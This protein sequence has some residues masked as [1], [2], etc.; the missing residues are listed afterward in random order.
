MIWSPDDG[1]IIAA[2]PA[3]KGRRDVDDAVTVASA[4]QVAWAAVQ[5]LD[6]L[7]PWTLL[8]DGL[9]HRWITELEALDTQGLGSGAQRRASIKPDSSHPWARHMRIPDGGRHQSLHTCRCRG[10][11]LTME[12]AL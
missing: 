7:N 12:S 3:S 6:V 2:L 10:P 11:D 1:V 8:S 9:I 5:P 4:A